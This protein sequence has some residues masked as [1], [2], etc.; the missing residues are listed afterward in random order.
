[1]NAKI[2]IVKAHRRHNRYEYFG[3]WYNDTPIITLEKKNAVQ[4]NNEEAERLIKLLSGPY[5]KY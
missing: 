2:Y 3:G 5:T 4:C 1:M